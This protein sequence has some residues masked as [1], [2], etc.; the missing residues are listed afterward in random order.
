MAVEPVSGE[1][2][3]K[4]VAVPHVIQLRLRHTLFQKVNHPGSLSQELSARVPVASWVQGQ[5]T[6]AK[7]TVSAERIGRLASVYEPKVTRRR[8][9]VLPVP[10]CV[11]V[12]TDRVWTEFRDCHGVVTVLGVPHLDMRAGEDH[13]HSLWVEVSRD[14]AVI[15]TRHEDNV[16]LEL[17]DRHAGKG[18]NV[19]GPDP[20]DARRRRGH[21]VKDVIGRPRLSLDLAVVFPSGA[22]KVPE[23]AL[24][25]DRNPSSTFSCLFPFSRC[26]LA[27]D[28]ERD[29]AWQ[30]RRRRPSLHQKRKDQQT[31]KDEAGSE[32]R[33]K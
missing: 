15:I 7:D 29:G 8:R 2:D 30:R 1:A 24:G 33:L 4:A 22:D 21:V 10:G 13:P 9:L 16:P 17:R 18:V 23:R 6:V 20:Q 12:Q 19:R 14:R 31:G 32:H 3:D 28:F 27:N 11:E 5:V 26:R 25:P